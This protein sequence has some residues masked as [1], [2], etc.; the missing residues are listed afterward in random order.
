MKKCKLVQNIR[1]FKCCY[2]IFCIMICLILFPV[3]TSAKENSDHIIR[4]GS[5]EETYNVVNEKGERSGYGYE[6]LQDIA[7]YAGWTY[8]YIT[9]D[10]KNC[11]TQLENGEIDILGG[12]S[13]TD[14]RAEN[15]LFSDMPMGEEKYYI[16]TD[17]SNMDL[18]AGNLDSFEGKNIGVLKDHIPEDM[19]NEWELKYGLH[20]QH[21]NASNTAEVMDKL[22]KHEIDCFVSVEES[23]WEESDISPVTS[24]GETEIYFAIN[25]KRPDIKKALDSAMRR[26][27]DDN[28]FYT[29]DLYRR[30]LS[31]QSSSFLSKEEREWIGQ[32]GAIR[33]G[34]LNQDGGISSVDPSTGKLTGVITD[35]VDLAENCLQGQTLEF[36]LNGYDTRSELLQA[37]QDGKIDLIF[38]A[39]QNPYFAETNGFALSDTLLTL[40]MAAITA[41]DSFDE[42][43]ENL[44]AVE[45]EYFAMKAY[46]SYNYPQWKIMEYETSDAAEDAMQKGEVDCIV[47]NSS[48][49]ADYLKNKK[50]SSVFLTKEAD[51]SFAVQQGEPVLLSILNKT[52]TSMPTTQ[53]SGAVVSYNA[54]ARKVTAKD[55]IQDNLQTVSLIVGIS[56]FVVLCIILDSLKKSKR[57]EER[58]KKSAEQALKLN[59]ELEEKQQ[60]LQNALVE[61]QSANKAKTSFLNNM[62]HDIRTPMNVIL[63]YAQLMEEEL[64]E[65][66]LPETKEH[67]EKLQQSGKLLLSIINNVLDMARIESGK[68]ELDE[69]YGRIEDFRQSVF[70]VFDAEAKKKKI[71]F[72]Y[73]MKVEHEHVLTDVTKVKEI[74]VNILSNAMK[75]TPSG[76]SVMVSLE[77]LPCDEPGYMIVRTR[78]SDTGIGM[79]QD[80]LT[81]I[82]EA[83]TREQNTTKSKIAGTGLG[84][85]IVKKY[86]DLLGGT[87]QVESELGKGS[88]FTVTL[89]HK[90][91]DESYYGKGQIENPETGTEILKGRNILIAEDNDLNAEIAAA[92]LERAGLK[93]ERVENGVQCV[94]L[95]TK[96]PAGTY[97][98]IL[99]DIQMPEMDGYEAARVIRQLPDRDKACIP[100]IA[101]TANAFEED[102]KDAMAAGMNGHM[103]KPIQV[104]QLLSML[105]EM[106]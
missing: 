23:R 71:A 58:S 37:L 30:Y 5:F 41:K 31:A 93:T 100:I 1:N 45:K 91:A 64:K 33:I 54:S 105:A 88:T 51:V 25:P 66:E 86:V 16:Y 89:K 26:I 8:K 55:F 52:L 62:S 96:M 59:Q 7:G 9:S 85:S 74:F 17:A 60:E 27:K 43:K 11:F 22:S 36:E 72:Q 83:F 81:R 106:I 24:I 14:E 94:N 38:H 79:S 18:T 97:D 99:M 69:S 56:F 78:I 92:I 39:N 28:P 80:Y 13:Y 32:H 87:I 61:A 73:T 48:R 98:M 21:V 95:I 90:I 65:K 15:M 102:R 49:V 19:L 46:L 82:F 4:V 101:M 103:A 50:L 29:D 70:A 20:T 6:Y 42:N 77:E 75:Y 67:L 76:G 3:S 35:Y 53:F 12:I 2:F 57:A 104:D 63:G 84:M 68:M 34:Y 10:W 47:R 40:N 44:V